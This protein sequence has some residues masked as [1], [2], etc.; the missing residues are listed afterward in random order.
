MSR[1]TATVA[2]PD[3]VFR[4]ATLSYLGVMVV[5]P[6]VAIGF[7]A[8]R[9]GVAAFW[10]ALSDPFAW[11][12]LK[13][14]CATAMA[15]VV[16]DAVLGTATAW[17]LV[18]NDFPGKGLVN[19]LIGLPFAVPTVVTGVMLV[20]LFGPASVAGAILGRFGWGVIYHQPGIILAL[21]CSSP[22]RSSSAA[23]SRCSWSW[24]EPRRRP[25]RRS[26]PDPRRPSAA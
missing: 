23:S 8:A 26:G 16:V 9:P 21:F 6:M 2:A 14:T 10:S 4:G 18:R 19:A 20:A 5:L 17:V 12:A 25:R 15:M 3:L 24:T 13:L 22:T 11:H 7:E 1:G